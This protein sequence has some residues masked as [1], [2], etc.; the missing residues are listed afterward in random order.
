MKQKTSDFAFKGSP[1]SFIRNINFL[2]EPEI[3]LHCE[4]KSVHGINSQKSDIFQNKKVNDEKMITLIFNF[5]RY[6]FS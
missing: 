3:P 6:I 4:K 5:P 1:L 2:T